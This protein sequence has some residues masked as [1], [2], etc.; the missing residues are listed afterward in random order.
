MVRSSNDQTLTIDP[1]HMQ[2]VYQGRS[3]DSGGD[4]SQLPYRMGLLTQANSNC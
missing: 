2:Y 1:C 3:P 4:Y